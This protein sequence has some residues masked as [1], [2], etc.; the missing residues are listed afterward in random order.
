MQFFLKVLVLMGQFSIVHCFDL[1]MFSGDSILLFM[2]ILT[3]DFSLYKVA[4]N[5]A[6]TISIKNKYY[7]SFK[8][9]AGLHTSPV[10]APVAIYN[11]ADIQKKQ[12]LSENK[13]KAGVYM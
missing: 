3:T 12:I 11:N 5:S 9:K 6:A 1:W 7:L 8:P 13:G 2:L 4:R 10:I